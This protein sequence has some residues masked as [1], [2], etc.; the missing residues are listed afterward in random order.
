[1]SSSEDEAALM[2]AFKRAPVRK[3]TPR[4]SSNPPSIEPRSTNAQ[5]E[6]NVIAVA[7][8]SVPKAATRRALYVR[9]KPISNRADY[10][11]YEP[12]DEVERIVSE[13]S[14]RGEMHYEVKLFSGK[15]KQVSLIG[16]IE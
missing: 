14:R 4:R 1:M 13:Y 12:K 15:I 5:R 11:Y 7:A 9:V 6:G 10:T 3:T 8:P 2:A 16:R